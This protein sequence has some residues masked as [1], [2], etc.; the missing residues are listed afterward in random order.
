MNMDKKLASFIEEF[1]RSYEQAVAKAPSPESHR[2]LFQQLSTLIA[3]SQQNPPS[4]DIFNRSVRHPFDYYQFGLDFF[5]PLIDFEHS[6]LKGIDHL[7]AIQRQLKQKDNVILFANHQTEPDPQIISLM[8]EKIDPKLASEIV[9][10]AGHRVIKDPVAIPFSLGCNLLCIYSKKY[11][12]DPAEEKPAKVLH[13]QRTM[14]KMGELLNEGGYCIYVAPSG[15]RDRRNAKGQI[16]VAPFDSPSI[17]LFWLIA[18]AAAHPTHFYPLAL[19]TFDLMPPPNQVRKELGE[20]RTVHRTPVF[21]SF[22][23]EIEMEHLPISDHLDK[24]AKRNYRAQYIWNQV[25]QAYKQLF[26]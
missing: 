2:H 25:N 5:R 15:G 12:N 22:G 10:L 16:E 18:Q 17:E 19:G 9:C 21:L 7:H 1:R 14:K 26:L 13:N 20:R 23:A 8:I 24:K 4:F 11:I 3:T 6:K